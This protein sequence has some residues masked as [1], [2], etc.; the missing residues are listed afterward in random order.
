MA[1]RGSRIVVPEQFAQ[2]RAHL[3]GD[4]GREWVASLPAR[5]ERLAAQWRLTLDDAEPLHGAQALVVRVTRD[6]RPLV[7]K[8]S[9]PQDWTTAEEATGLRAWHGRGV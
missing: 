8:L 4:D 3:D 9:A 1:A 5:V 2:W 6:G 7:L